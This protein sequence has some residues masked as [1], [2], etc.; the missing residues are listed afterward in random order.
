MTVGLCFR[1]FYSIILLWLLV[2]DFVSNVN[3]IVG[4]IWVC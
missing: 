4:F 1:G 2:F 3:A